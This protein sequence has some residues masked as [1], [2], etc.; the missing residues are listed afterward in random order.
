MNIP[1]SSLIQ[2]AAAV[3]RGTSI[4]N[5]PV[6]GSD[7]QKLLENQSKAAAAKPTEAMKQARKAAAGLVSEALILPVLRQVR[8]SGFNTDGPFSPGTGE[9]TFGPE[10]DMQLA[11]RIAQSPQ[12]GVTDALAKRLLNHGTAGNRKPAQKKLDVHG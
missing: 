5:A 8:Q 4:L 1:T 10:F 3:T 11:D 6:G 9:K 7:F 2:P 12:M